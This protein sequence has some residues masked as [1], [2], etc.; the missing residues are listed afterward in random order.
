MLM[1]NNMTSTMHG[2]YSVL[3]ALSNKNGVGELVPQRK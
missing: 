1:I 2:F 3:V